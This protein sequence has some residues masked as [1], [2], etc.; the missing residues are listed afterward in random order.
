VL[1]VPA[2]AVIA[3]RSKLGSKVFPSLRDPEKGCG[4]SLEKAWQ[5]VR[6]RADLEDVR[7]H[8]LRHSFASFGAASGASLLLIGK[9]LGH[10]QAAT[11]QRYAHLG[12][13]PVRD[14]AESVGARI[15]RASMRVTDKP[16]ADAVS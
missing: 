3:G 6:K 2:A 15:M 12:A 8:D 10:S 13:D 5:R 7:L 16:S 11:T 1:N 9:A 4:A 14:L